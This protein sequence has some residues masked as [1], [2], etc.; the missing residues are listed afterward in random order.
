VSRPIALVV[1]VF[2]PVDGRLYAFLVR[3]ILRIVRVTIDPDSNI[4][5]VREEIAGALQIGSIRRNVVE[6]RNRDRILW[7]LRPA[8]TYG[9]RGS[10]STGR[11]RVI[12]RAN[13]PS[14]DP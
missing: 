12:R 3:G 4:L 10:C 8:R 14:P 5:A 11:D 7:R 1:L 13:D 6:K 9:R 2:S